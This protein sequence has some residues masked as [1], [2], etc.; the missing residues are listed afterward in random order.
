MVWVKVCGLT[1]LESVDAANEVGV[2]A[3]G[4]V[5]DS[6]SPRHLE[7]DL[8]KALAAQVKDGI[9][10]VLVTRNAEPENVTVWA[11]AIGVTTV[12]PHGQRQRESAEAAAE[13]GLSVLFP[14]DGSLPLKWRRLVDAP[15]PGSG[16]TLDWSKLEVVDRDAEWVLA[17][18]LTPHNVTLAI[19]TAKPWGVDASS[20]LESAPGLKD[21]DLIRAFVAATRSAAVSDDWSVE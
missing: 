14:G 12:Q 19:S 3:V 20:G 13:L 5:L 6:D 2:D 8:A 15:T 9:D 17:G 18:G 11:E 4:L 21:P 16:K 10:V 1:T 7:L